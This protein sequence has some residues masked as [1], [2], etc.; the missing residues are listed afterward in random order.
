MINYD[1]K[2]WVPL[3]G[4]FRGTIIPRVAARV[5]ILAALTLVV[6][7]VWELVPASQAVLKHFKPLGHV[8]IGVA[9]GL[10]IVFRNNCS[11]DRYWEGRKLWGSVVNSARNLVRE[12]A[13]FAGDATELARLVT[14]YP[15]ALKQHLRNS[16]DLEE[17]RPILPP[18]VFEHVSSAGNPPSVLAYYMTAWIRDRMASGKF[19]S[20]TAQMLEGHVKLFLDFQGGCERILK[21]PIPFAYAVHIKQLLMLYLVTLPLILVGELGWV[22]L[23]AVAA[24][25]FG[26]LG[27]EEAGV[28]I[29]DPFGDDPNDLP[30]EAICATIGRD[31]QSLADAP[32]HAGHGG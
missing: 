22:A 9:L 14:A 20:V 13:A 4:A 10:L 8:L 29:E 11:Y 30:L 3:T 31:A 25:G 27:I 28:E 6:L 21:T 24:I 32:K 19:D 12:A 23:P 5:A 17:L 15:L 1:P 18:A 7:L 26:L 2:A 16:K